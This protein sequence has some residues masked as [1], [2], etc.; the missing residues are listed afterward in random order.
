MSQYFDAAVKTFTNGA[1]AVDR[2]LRVIRASGVLALA[3]ASTLEDG[4]TRARVEAD[5]PA[6]VIL[7]TK[8]GT[9]PVIASVAIAA[10]A[11]VFAAAG[12]KVAATGTVSLGHNKG[13]AATADGDIIELLRS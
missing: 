4:V 12:G 5:K 10:D 6:G 7:R 3:D 13:A 1:T 9:V 2:Y 8:P 11:E